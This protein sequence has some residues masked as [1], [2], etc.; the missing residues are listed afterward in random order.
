[1]W[2]KSGAFKGSA[3]G[4]PYTIL[5]P[6]PNA[7][8]SLHAGHAMYTVDDVIA[9]FKR[10]QGYSVEWIPGTDHAGFET[11]YV[12]EKQLSK[13]GKSRM[14]FDRET[15][16]KNIYDFVR[17]N[18][19][20]IFEQFKRLG[21]SADWE[22]SVF[23]LDK[24]VLE[25]VYETF[26]KMESEGLVYRDGYIVNYCTHCGTSLAELEVIHET[27]IEPLYYIKY[28]PF[29]L[30][31]VRPETKFG[32]TALAV[33]PKDK[34][35][36][37]WVGQEVEAEGLL[38]KFKI[39]VIADDYV[40]PKFGTGVVKITPAHDPNDFAVW[41]R[42]KNEI[43]AP[44][45]TINMLGRLTG[46][47]GKYEGLKVNQAREIV[48]RDLQEKGLLDKTD[49]NYEHSV[50]EC[51]K[52]KHTLEPLIVPN[53]FI[54]V[55]NL[56]KK[57]TKVVK[58]EKV[59]FF[60]KRFKRHMLQWLEIM[61]DWPISRQIVW[62]I[63]IPIWYDIDKNKDITIS[64][65]DKGG[66]K[67]F[68]NVHQIL[69]TN[70]GKD[71]SF[72]EI[73][74][75][76][77]SVTASA[78]SEYIVRVDKPKGRVLPETDTFD[79]WFSSGQWPIVTLKEEEFETRFPTDLMG[80]LSDILKFWVSRMI[81]FSLYLKN[82][83]PF[84]DVYLWSMVADARGVKMSKS[85]GNVINPLDLVDKY[86]ADA[87]RMSLLYGIPSGSKVVLSD[88]KVRGMRN[89][90]NKIWNSARFILSD[91]PKKISDQIEDK[92]LSEKMTK[93]FKNASASLEK[94]QLNH[95]SELIYEEFWHWFCDECIEKSK[96]GKISKSDLVHL[97]I[98]FLKLLHPF[99]P[100]VTEAVWSEIRN[101]RKYPDQLLITS[102]WPVAS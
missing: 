96:E 78:N 67:K 14:D 29:V 56:K 13:E 82:E 27:K 99:M 40:D 7:N 17:N 15:L 93:I 65:I 92:N 3:E 4:K 18:S 8:A 36:T 59:K 28:G 95:A 41:Q 64:F 33:H 2:E 20:V 60:P 88:E 100:F 51:Y 98:N 83:I 68:G 30:A 75:G 77:Q 39:K 84:K 47:A 52:C 66:V 35:Y 16:Y 102:S 81:M 76:L 48:V 90:A 79:T 72:E 25:Q 53:W 19:G 24:Q 86:G 26:K 58:E 57:V 89:F 70:S 62:G 91:P 23:T 97:L 80:T 87:L 1:M 10:M 43:P 22:R 74:N 11:Q 34:R 55:E 45:Q 37:K 61:H 94:Y 85:K 69:E 6:P 50:V 31:T 54:K 49:Q 44:K 32:D 46:L 63:R 101:L 73:E 21:F 5:M 38:G 71:Y 12:Y 42:H 9:R